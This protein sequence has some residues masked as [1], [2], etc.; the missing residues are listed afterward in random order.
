MNFR[1]MRALRWW[2][3][4]YALPSKMIA[5]VGDALDVSWDSRSNTQRIVGG[6]RL[7][8]GV[9]RGITDLG[10]IIRV[11]LDV[12]ACHATPNVGERFGQHLCSE[13]RV[14]SLRSNS[15]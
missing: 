13:H 11:S 8:Q 9:A 10:E 3:Q 5:K 4:A 2:N 15:L 14:Y 1:L 12:N 7:Y 6:H